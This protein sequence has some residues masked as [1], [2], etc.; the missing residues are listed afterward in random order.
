MINK[1]SNTYKC[2]F[3]EFE[4]GRMLENFKGEKMK[5]VILFG[6]LVSSF[7]FEAF[8][9]DY[10]YQGHSGTKYKYDLSNP[11]DKVQYDIDVNTQMKDKLNDWKPGV[12]LDRGM[13]QYGGGI[14]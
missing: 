6:L 1:N 2:L 11:M 8:A 3:V 10:N 4:K 14:Q 13:G 5:K 12:Q 7:C 9:N